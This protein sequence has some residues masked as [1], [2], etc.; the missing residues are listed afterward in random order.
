MDGKMAAS[1]T[2]I[3]AN[4]KSNREESSASGDDD[5]KKESKRLRSC[6]CA[7]SRIL[8]C[9][10]IKIVSQSSAMITAA[11]AFQPA[12]AALENRTCPR[13]AKNTAPPAAKLKTT[14]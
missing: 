7:R 4:Q 12:I 14:R 9:G 6:C 8:R 10:V 3:C 1:L 5:K 2:L 11:N 13:E